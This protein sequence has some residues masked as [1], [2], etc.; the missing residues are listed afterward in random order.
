LKSYR[1]LC[2]VAL[3][4]LAADTLAAPPQ[5]NLQVLPKDI[6]ESDLE[7]TMDGFAAQLGVTCA[8]CHVVEQYEKDEKPRKAEARRMV[9]L[10]IDM[11]TRQEEYFG[12]RGTKAVISCGMCHRGKPKPRPFVP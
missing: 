8:F 3:V 7:D 10:V 12:G 1:A 5:R 11:K 4:I 2:V 9:K 6:S